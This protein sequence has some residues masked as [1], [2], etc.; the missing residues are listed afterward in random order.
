M[1]EISNCRVEI[2]PI[3]CFFVA[4]CFQIFILGKIN[5]LLFGQFVLVIFV[6]CELYCCQAITLA[7]ISL[8]TEMS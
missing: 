5:L 6:N 2:G 8:S 7:K 3:I 4:H 1:L